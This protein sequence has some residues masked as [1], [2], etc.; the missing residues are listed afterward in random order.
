MSTAHRFFAFAFPS[1][2]ILFQT[3]PGF[4]WPSGH[5]TNTS[6]QVDVEKSEWTSGGYLPSPLAYFQLSPVVP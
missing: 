2:A 5:P 3:P 4:S 6:K 1:C